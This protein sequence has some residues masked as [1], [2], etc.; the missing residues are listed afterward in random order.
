MCVGFCASPNY[1]DLVASRMCDITGTSSRG[2]T[3]ALSLSV[4][5]IT[6]ML[7][8]AAVV[9]IALGFWLHRRARDLTRARG[10]DTPRP[11]PPKMGPPLELQA[12]KAYCSELVSQEQRELADSSKEAYEVPYYYLTPPS[13]DVDVE[14]SEYRSDATRESCLATPSACNNCDRWR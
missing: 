9:A 8:L 2:T 4:Q 7:L 14:V 10:T 13:I 5:F 1:A 6:V 12:W 3:S 11:R